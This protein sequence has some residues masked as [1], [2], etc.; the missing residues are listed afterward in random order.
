MAAPKPKPGPFPEHPRGLPSGGEPVTFDER[1]LADLLNRPGVI[2]YHRDPE[3]ANKAFAPI[4]VI[5]GSMTVEDLLRLLG[6][7]DDDDWRSR[8]DENHDADAKV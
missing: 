6:R 1:R 7:R 3:L 4:R 2:V 5:E 8:F